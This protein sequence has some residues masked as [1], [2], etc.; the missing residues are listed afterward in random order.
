MNMNI[1]FFN[2]TSELHVSRSF[3]EPPNTYSYKINSN[4]GQ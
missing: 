2:E 4:A 3:D 1:L